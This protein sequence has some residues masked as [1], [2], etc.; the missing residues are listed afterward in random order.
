MDGGVFV[1]D[2]LDPAEDP[3]M[4]DDANPNRNAG[5]VVHREK[6]FISLH[7]CTPSVFKDITTHGRNS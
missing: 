6:D 2:D 3:G 1:A 7:S 5:R 4:S